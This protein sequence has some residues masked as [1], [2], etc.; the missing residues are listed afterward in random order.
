MLGIGKDWHGASV[1]PQGMFCL[2]KDE[3]RLWFIAGRS[4]PATIHPQARPGKFQAELWKYDVAELFLGDPKTGRYLELNL[5]PNGAWW[6]CEFT[7]PRQRLDEMDRIMPDVETHA[8]LAPDGAWLVAAALPL[9]I[10]RAR[11]GFGPETVGNVTFILNS[12][13]QIFLT[14]VPPTPGEPDFHRP[15]AWKTL[16]VQAAP[17]L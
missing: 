17:V 12:P 5:A 8:D 14:A 6:T 3:E 4:A 16:Q 10:L 1:Q 15:D 9:D 7:G 11:I 13:D 2:A